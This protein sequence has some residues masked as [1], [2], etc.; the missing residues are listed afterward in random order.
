VYLVEP[1]KVKKIRLQIDN[2]EL[3]IELKNNYRAS[4]QSYFIEI[5][6]ELKRIEHKN[7]S[8]NIFQISPNSN[9]L[10]VNKFYSINSILSFIPDIKYEFFDNIRQIEYLHS[11]NKKLL[12]FFNKLIPGTYKA[13]LFRAV[14]LYYE[15]GVYF[16]C[17][18]ILYTPI[19]NSLS[20]QKS[21]C[22]D[23]NG[24][25]YTGNLFFSNP[26]D[27]NLKDYILKVLEHIKYDLYGSDHLSVTA[28]FLLSDYIKDDI[29]LKNSYDNDEWKN[30]PEEFNKSD[31]WQRSFVVE[32]E[33]GKIILKTSYHNYYSTE[34][35]R[36]DYVDL[37]NKKQI[38]SPII[39]THD[40][41]NILD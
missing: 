35:Q 9:N 41:D 22:E 34:T 13:D 19:Y 3:E 33:T 25:L 28:G 2:D 21:L 30:N 11:K 7:Y 1:N 27:K 16:D 24:K 40:I 37:Y 12:T 8:F 38:Y 5:N 17:K 10:H 36:I 23:I 32:I 4:K 31:K 18:N 26:Y 29:Y 15:S 39:I 14:Y 20:K 6:K